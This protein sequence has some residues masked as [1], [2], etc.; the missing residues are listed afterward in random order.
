L[1]FFAPSPLVY[2]ETALDL[3]ET[4]IIRVRNAKTIEPIAIPDAQAKI[5]DSIFERVVEK[6][7]ELKNETIRIRRMPDQTGVQVRLNV[8]GLIEE[9]SKL[10][11]DSLNKT[12][13]SKIINDVI[14]WTRQ[15]YQF[16][17][18]I[19]HALADR[20]HIETLAKIQNWKVGLD[21]IER[22]HFDLAAPRVSRYL[23]LRARWA[24]NGNFDLEQKLL[25]KLIAEAREP[26]LAGVLMVSKLFKERMEKGE[27]QTDAKT[28]LVYL[29]TPMK[30]A[31]RILDEEKARFNERTRNASLIQNIIRILFSADGSRFPG[32]ESLQKYIEFRPSTAFLGL[33]ETIRRENLESLIYDELVYA[34]TYYPFDNS[35]IR[36]DDAFRNHFVDRIFERIQK[37][38]LKEIDKYEKQLKK[39]G[40]F[41]DDEGWTKSDARQLS[42]RNGHAPEHF[43]FDLLIEFPELFD[44]QQRRALWLVSQFKRSND[45]GFSNISN[46]GK[47]YTLWAVDAAPGLK[48]LAQFSN[49]SIPD[50]LIRNSYILRFEPDERRQL[51]RYFIEFGG[52]TSDIYELHRAYQDSEMADRKT[53][54]WL[55]VILNKSAPTLYQALPLTKRLELDKHLEQ[56]FSDLAQL[57]REKGIP[58]KAPQKWWM[59]TED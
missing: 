52:E 6:I 12:K 57:A 43:N 59:S 34:V 56:Y 46:V 23:W 40:H 27:K 20:P 3:C 28:R 33:E 51:A 31:A 21:K 19:P 54:L 44:F 32:G 17:N 48:R 10:S 22:E 8:R 2:A 37:T 55:S 35:S 14:R 42:F 41:F 38:I 45:A 18:N 16:R 53:L 11:L 9:I 7:P 58:F 1:G 15:A 49:E 4:T 29:T 36:E 13:V 50:D 39:D 30:Q 24:S 26:Y 25:S 47:G 5:I